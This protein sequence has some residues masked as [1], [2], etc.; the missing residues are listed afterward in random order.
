MN[1]PKSKLE[2]LIKELPDQVD[3]YD[4]RKKPNR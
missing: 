2:A 3:N 1:I 4:I